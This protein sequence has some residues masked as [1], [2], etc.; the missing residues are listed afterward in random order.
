MFLK[1]LTA[2]EKY[3][4]EDFQNLQRPIQMQLSEK[5]KAFS[6]YFVPFLQSTPNFKRFGRKDGRHR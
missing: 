3:P 6:Q 1:T 5:R 4:V 2:D